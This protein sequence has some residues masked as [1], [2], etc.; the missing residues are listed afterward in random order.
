MPRSTNRRD[1]DSSYDPPDGVC[2]A[3]RPEP[4]KDPR[5]PHWQSARY[6]HLLQ[7][8]HLG[9]QTNFDALEAHLYAD[10]RDRVDDAD[11]V[12]C[13]VHDLMTWARNEVEVWSD[14]PDDHTGATLP[15]WEARRRAHARQGEP[16]ALTARNTPPREPGDEP[17]LPGG[18]AANDD[19]PF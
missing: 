13:L 1:T 3:C 11:H 5:R 16:W 18:P 15:W 17:P 6:A 19:I 8:L 12:R 10:L 7:V 2:L 4:H 14:Y 9:G